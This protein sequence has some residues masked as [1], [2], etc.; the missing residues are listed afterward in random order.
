M[1]ER[2]IEMSSKSDPKGRF[3]KMVDQRG[4]SLVNQLDLPQQ[5]LIFQQ[6]PGRQIRLQP[7]RR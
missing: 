7:V 4:S 1:E 3:S 2:W 5:F 6:F